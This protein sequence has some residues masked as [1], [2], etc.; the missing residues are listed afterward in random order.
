MKDVPDHLKTQEVCNKMVEGDPWLLGDS[1][2]HLK[3]RGMCEKVVEDEPGTLEYVPNHFNTQ[4][5]CERAVENEPDTLKF[6]PDH[7]KTQ[8]ICDKTVRDDS[9][10]LQYV[11]D[12]FVT[13]EGVAMWYDDSGYCDDDENN[14]FKWYDG[15]KKRKAQKASKKEDLLPITWY[16]SR[17]WDWC[18]SEDEKKD[19]EA[20]WA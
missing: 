14:F 12:R 10:S 7:F 17:Y 18:I 15:Y 13:R 11:R 20:L 3:A 8:E 6:V 9:S 19:T 4:R 2:D 1:P 16:P 5:I